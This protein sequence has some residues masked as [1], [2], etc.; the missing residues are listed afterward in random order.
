MTKM[1]ACATYVAG[2]DFYLNT[3]T[4]GSVLSHVLCILVMD[5]YVVDYLM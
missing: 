2:C 5:G 3:W 4:I 1:H